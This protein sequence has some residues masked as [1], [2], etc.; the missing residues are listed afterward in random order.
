[1]AALVG[2]RHHPARHAFDARL[3]AHGKPKQVA[4]TA[5]R[6][7]LPISLPAVRRDGAPWSPAHAAV[8]A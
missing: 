7:K 4:L 5:W 2:G 8:L 3:V 6:Q 1:M